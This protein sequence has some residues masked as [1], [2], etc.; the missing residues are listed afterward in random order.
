MPLFLRTYDRTA[1]N[2]TIYPLQGWQYEYLPWDAEVEVAVI[3]KAS[4]VTYD[5]FSGSDLLA[6][7]VSA[8]SKATVEVQY[9]YDYNLQDIA[10]AGERIGITLKA[11]SGTA[12][13]DDMVVACRITPA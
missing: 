6:Q 12:A 13:S 7:D 11:S 5:C 3:S 4:G 2:Q 1:D 10:A 9:P 8:V